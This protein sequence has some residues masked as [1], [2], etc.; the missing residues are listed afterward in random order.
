MN[1]ASLATGSVAGSGA[2]GGGR[3][4][5]GDLSTVIW[6]KL[7]SLQKVTE[8]DLMRWSWVDGSKERM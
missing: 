4:M 3:I 7:E 8:G 6:Q 1:G 5:G 2:S